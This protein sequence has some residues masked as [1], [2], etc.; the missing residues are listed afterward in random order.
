MSNTYLVAEKAM[1]PLKY[2]TG[3][4]F[5]DRGPIAGFNNPRPAKNQGAT[6]S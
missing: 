6:N 4:D 1:D 3:D 5:G 2:I